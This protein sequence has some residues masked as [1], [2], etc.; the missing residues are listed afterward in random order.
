MK[1]GIFSHPIIVLWW[2]GISKLRCSNFEIGHLKGD[3]RL[4]LGVA[5]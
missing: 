2:A 1:D 4:L 3:E 5:Q